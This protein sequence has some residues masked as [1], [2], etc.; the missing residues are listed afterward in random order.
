MQQHPNL[1]FITTRNKLLQREL[2]YLL[3]LQ[4]MG[5]DISTTVDP[6]PSILTRCFVGENVYLGR[7]YI[8]K[9]RRDQQ[10]KALVTCRMNRKKKRKQLNLIQSSNKKTKDPF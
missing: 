8:Y 7:Y 1:F 3:I 10:N 5:Q 4:V 2:Y 9:R 6:P